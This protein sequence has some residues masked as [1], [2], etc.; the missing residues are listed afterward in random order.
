M[1]LQFVMKRTMRGKLLPSALLWLCVALAG[2]VAAP[3]A[4]PQTTIEINEASAEIGELLRLGRELERERRWGEAL[5][6]YEDSLR[7][8]P[9]DES[10]RRRL[11]YSRLHYDVVRRYVDRSYGELLDRTS[12]EEAI[13]LYGEVLAKIQTHYVESPNW[14]TL[15]VYGTNDLEVALNE[16]AFRQRNL[17]AADD[18]RIDQFRYELR[19]RMAEGIIL[20]RAAAMEEVRR[21]AL[22]AQQRL[23][24]EPGAIAMEYTCGAAGALDA[25]STYLTPDQ[26]NDVYAQIEGNFVGLGIEIKASAGTL[27]IVRVIPGSPAERAGLSGGDRIVSIDEQPVKDLPTDKAASLL[28][29]AAG[30]IARLAVL[31]GDQTRSVSVRRD[32]VEVPSIDDAQIIDAAYGIGYL[33]LTCFQKTTA[34]DIDAALWNLHRQGMR[35]LVMD[36]RGNPGGLLVTAV[37]VVDKFVENGTI[38]TTRGRSPREDLVYTAHAVGTWAVPLVVLIDGNSASAAEIFAGAIRDHRRGTVVGERSYGKGSVQGIFPLDSTS[39]GVRLTTARF[40]SPSGKPYSE[41]GVSPDIS[42]HQVARP[43][44]GQIAMPSPA[45]D[46][47]LEAA[48][49]VARQT[50]AQRQTSR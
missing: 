41:I 48:L 10:L 20:S 49:Q 22:L 2:F 17:P 23:G 25:Y 9:A 34:R 27:L 19:R 12:F 39:A 18:L 5:A 15:I 14:K 47:F 21:I 29:G 7:K 38:V 8:H 42:V 35:S 33:K 26:L 11:D 28:Q 30:S 13:D 6:H 1:K 45:A 36:L 3:V 16:P 40:Y 44:D 37:E 46:A 50:V 31:S 32:R 24:A 4:L 43:T